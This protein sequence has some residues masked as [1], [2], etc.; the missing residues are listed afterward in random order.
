MASIEAKGDGWRVV[1]REGG[2]GS[3]KFKGAVFARKADA[4]AMG[5]RIETELAARKP[6][7]PGELL[8]WSQLIDRY[9]AR[10][11][12]RKQTAHGYP[13]KVGD[14]LTRLIAAR[15]WKTTADVTPGNAGVLNVSQH[16]YLKAALR[17]AQLLNQPVDP[18][19]VRLPLPKRARKPLAALLTDGEVADLIARA[20]RYSP[21]LAAAGHLVATYGHRPESLVKVTCGDVDLKATPPTIA[22]E[23]KSGDRIRHPLATA[24]V[25]ILRPLMADRPLASPLLLRTDGKAWESGEALALY[26][27]R[28]IGENVTPDR[29]GI[30]HL[31]R[32][33]ITRLLAAGQDPATIASITGHRTPSVI[34]TYARTNEHRQ[35]AAIAAIEM[36]G[37]PPVSPLKAVSP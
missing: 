30:Y 17:F 21:F 25:A 23:V 27:Y 35:Q 1:W 9:K 34:L 20:G 6:I 32:R 36:F 33:A 19:C 16:R 18:R 11:V 31:K 10:L 24:T 5:R 26:W 7:S 4:L 22:M 14:S 29:P 3:K 37:V 15:R 13:G 12:E 8:T 28:Q 2:R